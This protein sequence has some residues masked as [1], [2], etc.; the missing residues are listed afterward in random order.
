MIETWR[1]GIK[2]L[3]GKRTN[4]RVEIQTIKDLYSEDNLT[5]VAKKKIHDRH[6]K[7]EQINADINDLKDKI[8]EERY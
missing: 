3:E 2:N 8:I 1:K 7:I 4:L 6:D 5:S